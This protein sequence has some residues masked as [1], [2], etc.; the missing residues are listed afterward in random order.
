MIRASIKLLVVG[1]MLGALSQAA[2]LAQTV[3]L[4]RVVTLVIPYIPGTGADIQTRIVARDLPK[5]LPGSPQIIVK[6]DEGAGGRAG[7][8][9]V[10]RAK[11]DGS[12]FGAAYT[13]DALGN[14]ALYGVEGSGFDFDRV[15]L[16]TSTYHQPYTV[17]VGPKT[18]YKNLA[19]LKKATKP[20]SFCTTLGLD[21]S[22][23]V[24]A[25]KVIGFPV[26]FIPGFKG[27]P[28]ATAALVR[29][30]CEAVSFGIEFTNRYLKEGVRPVSVHAGA[31][32]ELWPNVPTTTEQGYPLELE[33]SL[34]FYLPPASTK[35]LADLYRDS[36]TK[37]YRDQGFLEAIKK[38]GFTPTF[39][40]PKRTQ[41][42][43]TGL[44][45]LFS[46][47]APDLKAAAAEIR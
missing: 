37:L 12:L 41:E 34:V 40:D 45:K 17:S 20:V 25:S 44:E 36:L 31:R 22:Y 42:I 43:V 24:I 14:Q 47:Y 8:Q 29:G 30:D 16:L 27:A 21:L 2:A 19:D 6:N 32:Q 28:T 38:A 9:A 7:V 39:A 35:E 10:Y 4:S 13:P 1:V 5:F 26:R 23:I 15:V 3:K 33:L 46:K 11:P 18:P